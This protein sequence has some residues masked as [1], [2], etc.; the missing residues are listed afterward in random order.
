MAGGLRRFGHHQLLR[1]RCR[2]GLQLRLRRRCEL[3]K[4]LPHPLPLGRLLGRVDQGIGRRQIRQIAR[5]RHLVRRDFRLDILPSLP[6][7]RRLLAAACGLTVRMTGKTGTKPSAVG[8]HQPALDQA[9]AQGEAN[10][11]LAGPTDRVA[12]VVAK[13]G[14]SIP[15]AS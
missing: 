14:A 11:R 12:V 3:N 1:R 10:E 13:I 6:P 5:D 9:M 8:R 4:R 15:W 2:Q 7:G